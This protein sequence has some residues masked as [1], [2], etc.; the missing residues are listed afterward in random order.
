MALGFESARKPTTASAADVRPD[1]ANRFSSHLSSSSLNTRAATTAA[2]LPQAPSN[3]TRPQGAPDDHS[4]GDEVKLAQFEATLIHLSTQHS[5]RRSA[6]VLDRSAGTA[7]A[8]RRNPGRSAIRRA[9][10]TIRQPDSAECRTFRANRYSW[11]LQL[12]RS[13]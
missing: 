11:T 10:N 5:A 6:L 7:S 13:R 9:R 4:R 8:A 1:P 12:A 2:G 3:T